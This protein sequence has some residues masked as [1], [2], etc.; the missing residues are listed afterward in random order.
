MKDRH[1]QGTGLPRRRPLRLALGLGLAA[2]APSLRAQAAATFPSRPVRIVVQGPPGGFTDIIARS[3]AEK[4]APLLGQQVLVDNRPGAGGMLAGEQTARAAP[5]GHTLMFA[6]GGVIVQNQAMYK[7]LPYDPHKDFTHLGGGGS[8]W[9]ICVVPKALPVSNLKELAAYA[10]SNPCTWGTWGPGSS[11]H[12]YCEAFNRQHKTRIAPVHYKGEAP[13]MQDLVGNQ[14]QVGMGSLIGGRAF[15]Q[16]GDLRLIAVTG[17]RRYPGYPDTATF[18]EQ[19]ASDALFQL[20]GWNG[21]IGPAGI[22]AEIVQKLNAALKRAAASPDLV[23][24]MAG[25]GYNL[26]VT[27]PEESLAQVRREEPLWL[28]AIRDAGIQPE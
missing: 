9:T 26:T 8:G 21:F 17:S 20:E 2:A 27:S 7:K 10:A 25:L 15:I 18:V 5:D 3:L 22:P 6:L 24:K 16:R 13:I 28:K 11:S 1:S 14:I 12:L 4:M 23:Q 19:G